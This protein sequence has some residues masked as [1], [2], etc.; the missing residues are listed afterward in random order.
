MSYL[1]P[2]SAS[3]SML[4]TWDAMVDKNTH[5]QFPFGVHSLM[6]ETYIIQS[7]IKNE[8]KI[9]ILIETKK[10]RHLW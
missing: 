6:G 2:R 9:E 4:V 5:G 10:K 8:C 1:I 3:G 7:I